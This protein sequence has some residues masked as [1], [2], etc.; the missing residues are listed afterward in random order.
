MHEEYNCTIY[1]DLRTIKH[2]VN[3]NYDHRDFVFTRN[4]LKV[5]ALY[6]KFSRC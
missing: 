5:N 1:L 3:Y 6:D 4:V 2:D